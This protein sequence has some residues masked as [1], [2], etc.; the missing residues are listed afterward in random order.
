MLSNSVQLGQSIS[1]LL[2]LIDLLVSQLFC[3]LVLFFKLCQLF[4]KISKSLRR[5]LYLL[6]YVWLALL[7]QV[8]KFLLSSKLINLELSLELFL[9]LYF[10]LSRL[11]ITL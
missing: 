6:Q 9:L 8:I 5:I 1:Q 2:K 10:F 7:N 4:S 11:Q 3:F